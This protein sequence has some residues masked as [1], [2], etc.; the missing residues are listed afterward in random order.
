MTAFIHS[1][2][3]WYVACGVPLFI[4]GYFLAQSLFFA[5]LFGKFY[6]NAYLK[7]R[8][9]APGTGMMEF[10]FE[11][12][13]VPLTNGESKAIKMENDGVKMTANAKKTS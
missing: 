10:D 4:I 13:P 12:D 3:A 9:T 7:D 5:Y 8:P 11:D 2:V 1:L 6:I